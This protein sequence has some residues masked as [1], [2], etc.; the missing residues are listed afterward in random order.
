MPFLLTCTYREGL[1]LR[2]AENGNYQDVKGKRKCREGKGSRRAGRMATAAPEHAHMQP[3]ATPTGF[4]LRPYKLHL[5]AN[6]VINVPYKAP[7]G[8]T[9]LFPLPCTISVLS[10]LGA[11]GFVIIH[12]NTPLISGSL[13]HV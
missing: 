6:S 5:S 11:A 9:T 7:S 12:S 2:W 8:P 4:M 13:L 3:P 10:Y 1:A